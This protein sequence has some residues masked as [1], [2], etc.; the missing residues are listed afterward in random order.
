ME[1]T[2][3]TKFYRIFNVFLHGTLT[4]TLGWYGERTFLSFGF[5]YYLGTLFALIY[6]VRS[7]VI[8]RVGSFFVFF[9]RSLISSDNYL[10]TVGKQEDLWE[11]LKFPRQLFVT[12]YQRRNGGKMR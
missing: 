9:L 1:T 5:K 11:M 10:I 8:S 7:D 12:K 3:I 4:F 6:F 2:R